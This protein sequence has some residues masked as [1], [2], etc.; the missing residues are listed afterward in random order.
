[1][2]RA[3]GSV[4]RLRGQSAAL[5]GFHLSPCTSARTFG[6]HYLQLRKNSVIVGTYVVC[7][8]LT[9]RRSKTLLPLLVDFL[10]YY[11]EYDRTPRHLA[12]DRHGL[13]GHQ[14]AANADLA[15]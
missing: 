3:G 13:Q 9:L 1:M 10:S 11:R 12:D 5:Q 7:Q 2:K 14:V 6:P 15:P 4:S 8:L